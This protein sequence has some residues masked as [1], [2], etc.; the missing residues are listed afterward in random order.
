[1]QQSFFI[2]RYDLPTLMASKINAVIN[3]SWSRHDKRSGAVYDVKGRDYFDLIWYMQKRIIPRCSFTE[4]E[5]SVDLWRAVA[6][7]VRGVNLS[8]IMGDLVDFLEDPVEAREF[9][10]H[11]PVVFDSLVKSYA[12]ESAQ[13]SVAR[14]DREF[15][16]GNHLPLRG[17][18]LLSLACVVFFFIC[19]VALAQS[20]SEQ[21]IRI[22]ESELNKAMES[23]NYRGVSGRVDFRNSHAGNI[24]K[25]SLLMVGA[26]GIEVIK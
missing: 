6:E 24:A 20:R 21:P 14:P 16:Y 26:R 8:S 22:G 9:A 15:K 18:K 10:K 5:N 11:L 2:R 12:V 19:G 17:I 25:A 23:V 3:R 1:M 4:F 13:Q 7:R